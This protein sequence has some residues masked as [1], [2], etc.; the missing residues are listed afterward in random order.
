[1]ASDL[2]RAQGR[3]TAFL[4]RLDGVRFEGRGFELANNNEKQ[5]P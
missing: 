5:P 1:V 4:A 3:P 2:E